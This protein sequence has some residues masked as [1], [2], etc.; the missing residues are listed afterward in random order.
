[1]I[2]RKGFA[3]LTPAAFKGWTSS[4]GI[5]YGQSDYDID[6][7]DSSVTMVTFGMLRQF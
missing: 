7:Y 6:F 4:T 5:A 3:A 2:Y 1:M